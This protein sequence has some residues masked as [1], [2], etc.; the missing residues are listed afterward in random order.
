[1]NA[2]KTYVANTRHREN[3]KIVYSRE[4]FKTTQDMIKKLSKGQVK[5]YSTDFDVAKELAQVQRSIAERETLAGRLLYKQ[6]QHA[7]K[8][9]QKS[10]AERMEAA[11]N[12][13]L[14]PS[15]INKGRTR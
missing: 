10:L 13:S 14:D 4:Q 7:P 12:R 15:R 8:P 1:M 3:L 11:K 5:T 9:M 2:N 6:A